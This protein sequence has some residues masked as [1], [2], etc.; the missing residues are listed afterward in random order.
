[1]SEIIK[2]IS[3]ICFKCLP[4]V[5][6]PLYYITFSKGYEHS[7]SPKSFNVSTSCV[8][9]PPSLRLRKSR[10]NLIRKKVYK[11]INNEDRHPKKMVD[12]DT[13][14]SIKWNRNG[15]VIDLKNI[16]R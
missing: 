10:I 5:R 6:L 4:N 14:I 3:K 1:M 8:K 12:A 7:S 13:I 2:K 9:L 15:M 11:C 16:D